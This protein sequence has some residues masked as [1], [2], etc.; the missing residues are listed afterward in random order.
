MLSVWPTGD[1]V[2]GVCWLAR[3]NMMPPFSSTM[4]PPMDGWRRVEVLLPGDWIDTVR[5]FD[6]AEL[7]YA[8]PRPRYQIPVVPRGDGIILR[9]A[10]HYAA[11][12]DQIAGPRWRR[13]WF[14]LIRTHATSTPDE[15]VWLD[16]RARKMSIDIDPQTRAERASAAARADYEQAAERLRAAGWTVTPPRT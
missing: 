9:R 7:N 5:T 10:G 4:L 2:D 11:V 3:P 6:L 15:P 13:V 14:D 8:D 16:V 12:L 1:V